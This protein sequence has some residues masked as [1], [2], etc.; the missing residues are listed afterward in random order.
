MIFLSLFHPP[1]PFGTTD[2]PISIWLF[3]L[4]VLLVFCLSQFV[5]DNLF[6]KRIVLSVLIYMLQFRLEA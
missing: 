6:T 5:L 4:S 2:F 1:N 3:F